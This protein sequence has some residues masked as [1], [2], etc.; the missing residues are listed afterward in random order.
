MQGG[1][2]YWRVT[3]KPTAA[4]QIDTR[5]L[6]RNQ[7]SLIG[8]TIAGNICEFFDLFLIGFVIALL[9]RTPGWDLT[10]LQAG[11]IAASSGVGTVLGSLVWGRMADHFGRRHAF[12]WCIVVMV[13]FTAATLTIQPGQWH[14]LSLYRVGVCVGVGGLNITSLPFVQEFVP[15]RQRGLLAG[16]TSVFIPLGL[17]LGSLATKLFAEPF[18]WKGLIALGCTPIVIL[19][20]GYSVPESPRFLATRGKY[21]AARD[22]YAW[23]MQIPHKQVGTVEVPPAK[24]KTSYALIVRKYPRELVIIAAASF[25]FLLGCFTIQSWG[26]TL[27]GESFNFDTGTVVYMFMGVSA[28]DLAGRLLG[29]WMSDRIGR[30]RTLL[31]WGWLGGTGCLIAAFS[32][33]AAD[34]G[35]VSTHAAGLIFFGG[36][37]LAMTFGDGSFG[38]LNAFGAEQFPAAARST[39]VG[40]TYGIGATAK[41]MGPYLVGWM[42]GSSKLTPQIVFIPFL[43]FGILLFVG[44]FLFTRARETAGVA[45]D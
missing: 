32:A 7:K 44:G 3:Q 23:A 25:C 37:L 33:K 6:T 13:A 31:I 12:M 14:L 35:M 40:M 24:E 15:A 10:G 5:P 9:M 29:A 2:H 39:G 11:I 17:F 36:I 21:Y 38:F 16:L 26:Q 18:G 4:E 42:I 1:G 41:I 8:L 43:L 27:L 34:S 20:W 28:V 19:L 30:R 45:L 22:A